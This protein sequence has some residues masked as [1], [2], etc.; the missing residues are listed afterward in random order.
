MGSER[1]S[2]FQQSKYAT[3]VYA[4]VVV[5]SFLFGTLDTWISVC[6]VTIQDSSLRKHG[7]LLHKQH[8]ISFAGRQLQQLSS[9]SHL[10]V[11]NP[12]SSNSISSSKTCRRD[13]TVEQMPHRLN[14]MKVVSSTQDRWSLMEV[15]R[16]QLIESCHMELEIF[17][18]VNSG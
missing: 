9:V 14:S 11:P 18:K 6:L 4:L 1:L 8:L 7:N 13:K 5:A 12:P 10:E 17:R 2:L 15:A 16:Q 3:R